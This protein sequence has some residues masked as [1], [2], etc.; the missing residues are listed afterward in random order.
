M[1]GGLLLMYITLQSFY[2]WGEKV[3]HMR[4]KDQY[5]GRACHVEDLPAGRYK[6]NRDTQNFL[7][8][9]ARKGDPNPRVV[10]GVPSLAAW[11]TVSENGQVTSETQ[12]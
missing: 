8:R 7:V 10:S 11:I 2:D 1:V 9:V 12:R 4:G 5:L 6:V 3:G